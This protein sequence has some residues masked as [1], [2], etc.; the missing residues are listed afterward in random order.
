MRKVFVR[1][2]DYEKVDDPVVTPWSWTATLDDPVLYLAKG[3]P[4]EPAVL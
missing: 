1:A 3:A 2:G 4:Y